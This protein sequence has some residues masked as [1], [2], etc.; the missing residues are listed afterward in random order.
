MTKSTVNTI[1]QIVKLVFFLVFTIFWSSFTLCMDLNLANASIRQLQALSYATATGTVTSS[2][3]Q[4]N[5]DSDGSTYRP[6]IKYT[7][8]VGG[9]Q[10]EGNRYRYDQ[11]G[12]NDHSSH[13]IVALY[14]V[15]KQVEVHHSPDDPANA[16]LHAGLEGIDLFAMM[17]MLPFNLVMLAMSGAILVGGRDLLHPPQAGG[18]KIINEGPYVRVRL[19]SWRPIHSAAVAAGGLA[20]FL[21]FIVG[22]GFGFNA[23]IPMFVAWALILGGAGFAHNRTHRELARGDSD[24]LIDELQQTVTLPRNFG[25]KDDV[26]VPAKNIVAIEVE[27]VRKRD[28]DGDIRYDYFPTITFTDNSGSQR[29]EKLTEWKD[30]TSAE[31]LAEWLRQRLQVQPSPE[32]ISDDDS[33]VETHS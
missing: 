6:L 20:F 10:Y 13:R 32:S 19:S 16:V 4:T 29:R 3:V 12:T 24:L 2:E 7:Y 17:F 31:A 5:D 9:K 33:D 15:G 14:P 18:A 30:E 22:L 21:I 28:S 26:V 1:G 23:L 27:E 11:M 25:R 8:V